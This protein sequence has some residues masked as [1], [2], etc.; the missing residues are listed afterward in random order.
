MKN[1]N[2]PEIVS[3]SYCSSDFE[4]IFRAVVCFYEPRIVAEIG[5]QQGGSAIALGRDMPS[6]SDLYL[7][8]KFET[9]YDLYPHGPTRVNKE[10]LLQNL[11]RA[12]VPPRI[13]I[14]KED[15]RNVAAR[16]PE[17]VD[18]LHVDIGNTFQTVSEYLAPWLSLTRRAILL[19]GGVH[20]RWQRE[21]G[22]QPYLPFLDTVCQPPSRWRYVVF[23]KDDHY[24]LTLLTCNP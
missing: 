14:E 5:S 13:H 3:T 4:S 8:D 21:N 16:H 19:E 18:I 17:G 9:V 24:A 1:H 11:E 22:H 20:N 23:C 6:D 7:Y 12:Q 2:L 15:V 10:L